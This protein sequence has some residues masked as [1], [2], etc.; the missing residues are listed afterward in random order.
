MNFALTRVFVQW[1]VIRP[2]NSLQGKPYEPARI[3]GKTDGD[4]ALIVHSAACV[5]GTYQFIPLIRM[6]S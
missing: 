5:P 1:L 3:T 6:A 4:P 2:G